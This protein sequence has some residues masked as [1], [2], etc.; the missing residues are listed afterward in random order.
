M[1]L[2]AI[3]VV[4]I[5]GMSFTASSQDACPDPA[6][7]YRQIDLAIRALDAGEITHEEYKRRVQGAAGANGCYEQPAGDCGEGCTKDKGN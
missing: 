1:R 2:S 5:M 7:T 3:L 6:E 4:A